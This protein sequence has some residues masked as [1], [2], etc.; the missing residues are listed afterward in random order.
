MAYLFHSDTATPISVKKSIWLLLGVSAVS[1]VLPFSC[2]IRTRVE[3]HYLQIEEDAAW[4]NVV[5]CE[6]AGRATRDALRPD[7]A[8]TPFSLPP[9]EDA[10]IYSRYQKACERVRDTYQY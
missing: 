9:K 7:L 5:N 8:G 3:R 4:D 2:Y 10:E 6:W 1:I